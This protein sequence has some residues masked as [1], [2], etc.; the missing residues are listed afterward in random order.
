MQFTEDKDL[1]GLILCSFLSYSIYGL[2]SLNLGLLQLRKQINKYTYYN[3]NNKTSCPCHLFACATISQTPGLSI[4]LSHV[5]PL[6]C[7]T[8]VAEILGAGG[9]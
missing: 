7:C 8:A 9:L 1:K 5:R 4:M 2:I 3:N 6:L